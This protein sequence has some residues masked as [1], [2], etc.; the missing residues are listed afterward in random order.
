MDELR[1]EYEKFLDF[2]KN[3]L[4]GAKARLKR[5]SLARFLA[6]LGL[7]LSFVYLRYPYN[8]GVALF[9][10][11]L[12]LYWIRSYISEEKKKILYERLIRINQNELLALDEIYTQFDGGTGFADQG[13]AYSFDLDLFGDGSLFQFLN[14]TVTKLGSKKLAAYLNN[15]LSD[16]AEINERQKALLE[17]AGYT[18]WRHHFAAKGHTHDEQDLR[19]LH[20]IA[21]HENLGHPRHVGWL[22]LILPVFSVSM[23]ALCLFSVLP[24]IFFILSVFLNGFVLYRYRKT[25][26]SFY[27]LFGNQ[28]EILDSYREL[29]LLIEQKKFDSEL[30]RRLKKQLYSHHKE[31]SR[32]VTDLRKIMARFDYRANLA[33]ALFAEPIFIWDLICV[34]QLNRWN[35]KYKNDILRWFDLIA[36]FDALSSLANLNHNHPEW[37]LPTFEDDDFCLSANE[38]AHPLIKKEKRIGNDFRMNGRGKIMIITGA[39][40]AGKSTFLRTIGVNMVLAM[41]GCRVCASWFTMKPVSLYTN[42]R[43]TDNLQKDESYFFAELLRIQHMLELINQ[44]KQLFVIIDEMLKGTNSEDKLTGSKALTEKLIRLNTNGL[45]A[46]HDL[47]LTELADTYPKQISNRCFEVKLAGGNLVFDYKLIDGVTRTMNAS[48]LMKK[49]KIID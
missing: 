8:I 15:P 30:L 7:I 34:Y 29:L 36:E 25:I 39:N 5:L 37:A 46:T 42:M 4:S 38:L 47:K 23:L 33:F 32:I 41:N 28:A 45:V 16:P 44:G 2:D 35:R 26:S 19:L 12:F 13:H 3:R 10:F 49:M 31:A 27:Q 6:F 11:S 9:A 20:Q 14:R 24:W 18:R 1:Q 43:T 40:M 22:I 48:Y 17:L 21:A